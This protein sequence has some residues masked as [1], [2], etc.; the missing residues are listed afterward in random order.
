MIDIFIFF[1]KSALYEKVGDRYRDNDVRGD[2]KLVVE[3]VCGNFYFRYLG[4][5]NGVRF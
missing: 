4:S 1:V 3:E 2:R 5:K